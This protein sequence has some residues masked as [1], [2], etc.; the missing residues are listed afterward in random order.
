MSSNCFALKWMEG[1]SRQGR[2]DALGEKTSCWIGDA[3]ETASGPGYW[4]I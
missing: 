3:E 2:A 4:L 1:K